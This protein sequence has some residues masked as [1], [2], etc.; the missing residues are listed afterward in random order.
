MLQ[1]VVIGAGPGGIACTKELI[2]NGVDDVLC[3]E[4]SRS[5]GGVFI[6]GYD[7][8]LLTSSVPFSMF[9]DFWVGDGK[10]H[11]FWS[12]EEAVAYW[13]AYA[14]HFGVTPRI[15]F[16]ARVSSVAQAGDGHW[17]V[18]L[19]S[20]EVI[21]TKHL[22]LA[23]GNNS[24]PRF[25]GWR[26]ALT[27]VGVHHSRD[28][29]N[30]AAFEGKR[31]L[32]V[33]GGESASDVALQVSKVA[34]RCWVSLRE[35][36][37]WVM[38]RKRGPYA[39]DISTHRG[40]WNLPREFGE[41]L[42]NVILQLERKRNDPV[43]DV[44]AD[45]NSRLPNPKGIWGTYGTKTLA[46]PEAIVHHGCGLVGDVR[47][48]RDGGR[49]LVTAD[50]EELGGIDAV[51][52]CTG[53][54]N[55]VPFL[56]DGLQ[57]CDPRSLYK[58]MFHSGT[59]P[60]L[61]FI[62]WAR[63]GFGSQFPIMEMQSRLCARVFT[64]QHRLPGPA[65]MDRAAAADEAAFIDQFG[66]TA[67]HLRS[68]VDYFRYMDDLAGIIGCQPPL[69]RYFFTHPKLWRH[70]VYGP[71]QATQFRLRGPGKKV[72]LAQ[73]ILHKLPISKLNHIVKA[74]LRARLRYG[75]RLPFGIK[76]AIRTVH[77]VGR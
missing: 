42:S 4:Q 10:G 54:V 21:A 5:L 40:V 57:D 32:V 74:G 38:P 24:V 61:A 75:V 72:A 28:Y 55:R 58:H 46:L 22:A 45:L 6:T 76:P 43:S 71:A 13:Q 11:H 62:G 17:D 26:D 53:Y 52:F 3:L 12:K 59:G 25:P 31:V 34:A 69:W 49:T 47:E 77:S 14:D 37:G 64:G 20:G 30:A 16:D 48:V 33:G 66:N 35:A 18:T 65:D 8:L 2:E 1:A 15:R 51:V 29:K 9:S 41:T 44:L 19:A 60:T 36:T 67:Q 68:L 7:D 39:A 50:G 70:I 63:P 23:T 73:G 27:A 56:P